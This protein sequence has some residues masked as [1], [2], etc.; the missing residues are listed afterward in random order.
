[1]RV[2]LVLLALVLFTADA[3]AQRRGQT[4]AREGDLA[5]TVGLVGLDDL[6]LRPLDGGIGLR[7]RLTDRSVVGASVGL[8]FADRDQENQSDN[9]ESFDESDTF[10]SSVSLW[11]ERHVGRS[12]VVSPFIGLGARARFVR[13]DA[14]NT[15]EPS[16]DPTVSCPPVTRTLDAE[17]VSVGGALLL[18]AEVKLARGITLGGAYTLGV[19]Y[20]ETSR[21]TTVSG[22]DVAGGGSGTSKSWSYGVGT[23]DL[24]LSVYF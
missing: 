24:S 3:E 11:T 4:L 13:T 15:F 1:M 20:S 23:T 14:S 19:D 8:T 17:T 22:P 21:T 7:Y 18:G 2:L 16:C 5:L 9:V 10:G 6:A 12:R